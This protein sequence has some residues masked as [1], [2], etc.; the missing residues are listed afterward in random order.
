[1][2]ILE[3]FL[4][5][6]PFNL[7]VEHARKVHECV[8]LV[9][10]LSE[11][12]VAGDHERLKVLHHEMSKMEHEADVVKTQVREEI[13]KLYFISVGRYELAQFLGFQ[14]DIADSAED[15]AVLL[16]LRKTS[17][18]EELREGF[19]ALVDQVIYVSECLLALSEELSELAGSAFTGKQ[20]EKVYQAIDEI[21]EEEWKA[22]KL[23][24]RFAMQFY[25][26][27]GQLDTTTLYFL[28]KFCLTLG[29]IANSAEKTAKYLRLIIS[30]G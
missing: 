25:G 7:L 28:D 26:M 17:M 23:Q 21:G 1:M 22:D 11:A 12:F 27:E 8:K 15:F 13:S 29:Q 18:P 10:P 14:D 20:V 6:S 2:G 9:K 5:K 16:I 3:R 4:G 24:R 30:R 19:L